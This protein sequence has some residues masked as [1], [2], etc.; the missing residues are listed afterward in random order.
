MSVKSPEKLATEQPHLAR[1]V[2]ATASSRCT[3][4]GALAATSI[5]VQPPNDAP[6][7]ACSESMPSSS[8]NNNFASACG[9]VNINKN[10]SRTKHGR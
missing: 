9:V 3:R 2:A 10:K 5:A 8:S 4:V 1:A 7:T 6:I